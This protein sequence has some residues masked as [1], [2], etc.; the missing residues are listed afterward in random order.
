MFVNTRGNGIYPPPQKKK[1]LALGSCG[2]G[3][4]GILDKGTNILVSAM[5]RVLMCYDIKGETSVAFRYCW[6][7]SLLM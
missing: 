1:H 4:K 7:G 3:S 2:W 6:I 5:L